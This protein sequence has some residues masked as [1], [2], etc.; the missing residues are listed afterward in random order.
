MPFL[1]TMKS[2]LNLAPP[3]PSTP[4]VVVSSFDPDELPQGFFN[5]ETASG[6][7]SLGWNGSFVTYDCGETVVD[8]AR[9]VTLDKKRDELPTVKLDYRG[10]GANVVNGHSIIETDSFDNDETVSW[11]GAPPSSGVSWR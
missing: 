1:D 6:K 7:K 8:G 9:R 2:I 11:A 10:Q 5:V 3:K 4:L